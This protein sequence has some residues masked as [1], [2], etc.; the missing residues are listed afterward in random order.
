MFKKIK[1]YWKMLKDYYR[2]SHDI[3]LHGFAIGM[4]SYVD[5]EKDLHILMLDYDTKDYSQVKE[6]IEELQ[7]FW[8][9]AD[10][11]IYKTTNG[12]HAF[13][14]FDI[15]PYGRVRM[16]LQYAKFVDPLYKFI[17]RYYDYKTIRCAGK[18][19][20]QDIKLHS[21]IT[22]HRTPTLKELEL[23]SLKCAEHQK[24][25]DSHIMLNEKDLS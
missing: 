11:H 24:L 23:G 8:R 6:S 2:Y 4:N 1:L 12:Y 17:S 13:F 25:L 10:C 20:K 22:G 16:I 19:K 21:I 9:L 15:M 18:Y 3:E 14:Y 7:E 5:R